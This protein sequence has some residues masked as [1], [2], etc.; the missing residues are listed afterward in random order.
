M[1]TSY[2]LVSHYIQR[3]STK[4][5]N[6]TYLLPCS[7]RLIFLIH[8]IAFIYCWESAFLHCIVG[9]RTSRYPSVILLQSW[10]LLTNIPFIET[11]PFFIQICED[12]DYPT[13]FCNW[14][15]PTEQNQPRMMLALGGHDFS[16]KRRY[17]ALRNLC[18]KAQD[19]RHAG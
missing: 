2:D 15:R 19:I 18:D 14:W 12:L 7:W 4:S 10:F 5:T 1:T 9:K 6:C 17:Q 8:Q 11:R 3:H 16:L 13:K